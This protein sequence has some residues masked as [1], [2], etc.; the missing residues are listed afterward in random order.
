[1]YDSEF[2]DADDGSAEVGGSDEEFKERK[3]GHAD[4]FADEI[5]EELQLVTIKV[6]TPSSSQL[7]SLNL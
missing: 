3:G 4:D 5:E 1:M 7:E 2:V 6:L